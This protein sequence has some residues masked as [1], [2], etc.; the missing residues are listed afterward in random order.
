MN[1]FAQ[2]ISSLRALMRAREWDAVILTGSD[3]HGSEYPAERYKQ[4]QWLTGFTGEAADLVVTA[5]HAGLWTDTRYFIQANRQLE[6]TGVELHKTRVPGQVLIPEWLA[7]YFEGQPE[8]VL[9]IDGAT[10]GCSFVQD[11][12]DAFSSPPTVVSS[13]DFINVLWEDRPGIPQTPVFTV[14]SG[15]SREEKLAMLRDFCA[16]RGAD[17]IL[18]TALDEIAWTLDVRASDIEY[19]PLVISYL[20]ITADSASWFVLKGD[21][22]DPDSERTFGLL[23]DGGISVEPYDSVDEAL[24]DCAGMRI[25]ADPASLNW[26]LRSIADGNGIRL[27]CCKS[28]VGLAKAVKNPFEIAGMRS[29]HV[30]DGVAMVRFLHWL[31][32]SVQAD[33]RVSEWDAAVRL[34]EFRS[35]ADGYTGDSFETISAYGPGAALPHYVTPSA[36]APLLEPSG[37]Y[38]CDSGGQYTDGTTDITRTVPLG[39]CTALEREDYTLVL[40]GHI[41]LAMAIFPEG[42]PGCRI[43]ALAREPLWRFQRNFG[44]GTGHGVGF[45]LGVH[46]GPQ[47]V[48]QNLNPVPLQAGM[49]ISDEPGIYREGQH[50]VRHENLLLCVPKG[51]NEFGSWLGFEPLTL[52]PFD[53]SALDLDLLDKAEIE[54]LDAYHS[55]VFNTLS[56]FLDSETNKWLQQKCKKIAT[57]VRCGL[58][59]EGR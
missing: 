18:L 38:L 20:L 49:I 11:V 14:E 51:Q 6:G 39:E 52:C 5:D 3:P 19:N 9:A 10:A 12:L 33:R 7:A 40:K 36:D 41:D 43:D 24:A 57:F 15:S 50:G 16:A 42:T 54:W 37:L 46:E 55:L 13:P 25:C 17:G 27:D 59:P 56:P 23:A 22:E 31:E 1:I 53:T 26:Q 48:R 32:R 29:C 44:H 2:R 4:I 47:D 45:F 21:V 28:P 30:R 58:E 35:E 34:R 8:P